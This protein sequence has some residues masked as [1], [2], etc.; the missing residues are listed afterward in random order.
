M[1][2]YA[3]IGGGIGGCSIA[4]LLSARGEEVVLIEKEPYIGG[5]ASTF[6]H[7]KYRYNTGATTLWGY[8]EGRI[9]RQLFDAAGVVP[10]LIETD[11]A[12]VTVQGEKIIKRH[13]NIEM[14]LES[15]HDA[16]PHPKHREFWYLIQKIAREFYDVE[17]YYYT[18][19]SLFKK[20]RS[21]LSF[22]PLLKRFFPYLRRGARA[23]I[24]EFYGGVSQEYLDFLDAQILIVAQAKSDSVNFLTA[25]LSLGYTFDP[26]HYPVGGM[27]RV[28]ES[29][30]SRVSDVR[31]S[32]EVLSVHK[33]EGYYR[34]FTSQ[35]LIEARNLILAASIFESDHL[36]ADEEISAYLRRYRRYDHHQSAF[37]LYLSVPT[38]PRVEHHYQL[39]SETILPHT[40]S[41]SLFVS[42]SDPRDHDIAPEGITGITASIHTDTRMWENLTPQEYRS[43]KEELRA[44]IE[45]WICDTLSLERSSILQS[46]AATPKTFGRYLGR[47][48]LGG[49]PMTHPHLLPLLPANDTPIEGFYHVGDT[50]YAAQG[51]PGIVMGAFNLMRVL[52]E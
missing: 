46:F 45:G 29:L 21:L 28:C 16:Y 39:I 15:L 24:E 42:L 2:E 37:V 50:T 13:R 22:A 47:T 8:R 44:L 11:P 32:H 40:L 49:I 48:R 3:I 43:R 20:L 27:G 4:A 36:F 51:W 18:N 34:I 30:V 23:V 41:Q 10:D 12:I 17:G 6:Q 5:C 1:K 31:M 9:L 7:G 52:D 25:A 38:P 33:E 14:F 26:N 19:G 35:G